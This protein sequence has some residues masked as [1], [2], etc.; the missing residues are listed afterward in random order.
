MELY[1]H[2]KLDNR[3]AVTSQD[4]EKLQDQG[5]TY[6]RELP[7]ILEVDVIV[8]EEYEL[9]ELALQQMYYEQSI[10]M[11]HDIIHGKIKTRL[12]EMFGDAISITPNGM[13][14]RDSQGESQKIDI[15]YEDHV[16][17]NG[18]TY[19]IADSIRDIYPKTCVAVLTNYDDEDN[20]EIIVADSYREP[21]NKIRY[22][23]YDEYEV[24]P[25]G[26][27]M[28]KMTILHNQERDVIWY[29]DLALRSGQWGRKLRTSEVVELLRQADKE[30]PESRLTSFHGAGNVIRVEMTYVG[31]E[32]RIQ[33]NDLIEVANH[34]LR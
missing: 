24:N 16:H 11:S 2:E 26:I 30:T 29:G 10:D 3:V 23:D 22:Y 14:C 12:I 7:E 6:V 31:Q 34:R 4:V 17:S 19:H 9:I 27:T 13:F 32:F 15:C 1:E 5:Y 28:A 25:R 33:H 18:D 21:M 20:R 8:G